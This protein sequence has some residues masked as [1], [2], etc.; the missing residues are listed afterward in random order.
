MAGMN[1]AIVTVHEETTC[2]P[3]KVF[4]VAVLVLTFVLNSMEWSLHFSL[5]CHE[6]LKHNARDK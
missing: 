2:A 3:F 5:V 6:R 4:S 1:K